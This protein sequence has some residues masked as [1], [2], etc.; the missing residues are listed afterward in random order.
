MQRSPIWSVVL[1]SVLVVGCS[2]PEV[3][4]PSGAA[5]QATSASSPPA[6]ASASVVER[7]TLPSGFPILSGAVAMVMPADDPGLIGL[8]ESDQVGSAAYDFYAEALP[9]AGY[10]IVGVYPGGDVAL[11]RFRAPSGDIWQVVAHGAVDG[12]TTIEV[13]LDRP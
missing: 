6:E 7:Q 12:G 3:S 11:I 10:P 8:W 13:R 1:L 2:S 9:V 4:S 5:S